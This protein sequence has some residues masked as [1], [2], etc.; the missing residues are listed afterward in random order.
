MCLVG[1]LISLRLGCLSMATYNNLVQISELFNSGQSILP[2]M[3]LD[4]YE[5]QSQLYV[6]CIVLIS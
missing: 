5:Q 4:S 1:G 3:Y 2:Y 6:Q